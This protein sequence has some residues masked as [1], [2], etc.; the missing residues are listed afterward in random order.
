MHKLRSLDV[1]E[2]KLFNMPIYEFK[3]ISCEITIE[4]EKSMDE[5]HKPICCG[6]EMHRV[7]GS[8]GISFKGTGWGGSK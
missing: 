2:R 4:M 3:C 1:Y 8:I 7:W 5:E 6:I